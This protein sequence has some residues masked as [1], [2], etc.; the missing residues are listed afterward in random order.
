[1]SL[2]AF[3]LVFMTLCIIFAAGLGV[4]GVRDYAHS[5]RIGSLLL[6]IGSWLGLPALVVYTVWFLRKLKNVGYL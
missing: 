6:G 2:K 4:W 5:A 3:H 1:M